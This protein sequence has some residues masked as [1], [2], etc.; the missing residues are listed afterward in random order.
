MTITDFTPV[1][2]LLGGLMIGLAAILLLL[3]SGR[4]AGISGVLAGVLGQAPAGDRQWRW[5]FLGGLVLGGLLYLGFNDFQWGGATALPAWPVLL[6]AV[7]VGFGTR[8]GNGCTSGH[9]ICGLSRFS[10]RSLVATLTFM[11]AGFITVFFVRH[12]IA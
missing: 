8:M 2:G 1:T 10:V 9:G 5:F 7:L 4:I 12:V 11:T 6:G 3:G